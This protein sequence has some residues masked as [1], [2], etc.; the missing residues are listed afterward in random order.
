MNNVRWAAGAAILLLSTSAVAAD[1]RVANLALGGDNR[2]VTFVDT[3]SMKT[4]QGKI[5]F[6]TERY[7]E[8]AKAGYDR[9]FALS[10]VDCASFSLTVFREG[11][12][13]GRVPIGFISGPRTSNHYSSASSEHWMLRR[14]CEDDYLSGSVEDQNRHSARMFAM[15]WSPL[16]GR[17]SI[18]MPV[19]I[20]RPIG[21]QLASI[22]GPPESARRR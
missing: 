19:S 15:D 2:G 11:F 5:R 7:F 10:E 17:L 20:A 9:I 13:S 21:E 14:I 1:W 4:K 16:P 6:R 22:E 3:A 8:S 18:A 12:Y